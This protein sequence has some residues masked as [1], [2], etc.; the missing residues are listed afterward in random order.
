MVGLSLD[1]EFEAAI[2]PMTEVLASKPKLPAGDALG[3]REVGNK[4]LSQVLSGRKPI[5]GISRT[6]H[7]TK[8]PDGHTVTVSEFRKEGVPSDNSKAIFYVHGGGFILG[9]VDVFE[10]GI[11]RQVRDHDVPVF[12]VHYRLAPE[13]QHPIPIEDCYAGLKWLSENAKEVGVDPGRIVVSGESAGGGLAACLTLLAR[14]RGFSPPIAK[15]IL[16]FP[17]LDD[18]N[19]SPIAGIEEHAFW[20]CNDNIT[21][22]KALVGESAGGPDTSPYAAAARAPDV[23]GLPPT[24][25]EVGQLDIF[26][27]ENIQFAGRLAAANVPVE[28]HVYPGMPHAFQGYA[29]EAEY[30]KMAAR[31]VVAA[32]A[33]A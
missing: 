18:R 24:Y 28:L 23:T 30:S 25:I 21:G 31:N 33:R 26:V 27:H 16:I 8:A 20:K 9:S 13:N 6:D 7:T 11:R 17:M 2:A 12:A 3:R 14:D 5:P 10:D 22:W 32:V 15:Q 19:Q 1:P 4:L 29:P